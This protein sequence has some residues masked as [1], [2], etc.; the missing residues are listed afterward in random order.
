VSKLG[1][2][3]P[4]DDSA[5]GAP[6]KRAFIAKWRS[7]VLNS[8]ESASEKLTLLTLAEFA[9]SN[10]RDCYPGI[11]ALAQ[12]SSQSEKTCWRALTATEGRWF[13]RQ[14]IKFKGRK[15]RGYKY[16]LLLP[17]GAVTESRTEREVKD[18]VSS[19]QPASSGHSVSEFRTFELRGH[20]T[21]SNDL[22]RA[23]RKSNQ[24]EQERA[25]AKKKPDVVLPTWLPADAWQSW[26]DHRGKKFSSRA[27]DLAIQKLEALR[28]EGH[29]PA[30]LIELGIESGW[31]SFYPRDSTKAAGKSVGTI[32]RDPRTDEEISA[33]NERELARFGMGAAA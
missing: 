10:G 12:L 21:E 27:Q 1:G 17:Q 11:E 29:D 31:S 8:D 16:Q 24:K 26:K 18:T 3:A 25:R 4:D 20:V 5:A 7:A 32:E 19:T 13:S 28:A 14:A 6:R 30:K 9:N 15:W 22:E 23:P 2:E 33:A